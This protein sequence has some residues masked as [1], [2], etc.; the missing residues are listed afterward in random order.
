MKPKMFSD[1]LLPR[2]N[3]RASLVLSPLSR[4]WKEGVWPNMYR[5]S[6]AHAAYSVRQSDA[7]NIVT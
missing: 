7:W 2:T 4:T 5:A 3:D 6:I 1:I